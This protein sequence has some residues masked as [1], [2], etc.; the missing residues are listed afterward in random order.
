VRE[1]HITVGIPGAGKSHYA[2]QLVPTVV[3]AVVASD[4]VREEIMGNAHDL[5]RNDDVWQQIHRRVDL[6][7]RN[8]YRILLDATNLAI[9]NRKILLDVAEKTQT[10]TRVAHLFPLDWELCVRRNI[11][12]DLTVPDHAM[13]RMRGF[14]EREC[15]VEQL[16]VE[17][18]D[19]T[20]VL[21]LRD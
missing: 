1:L 19:V 2:A 6:L 8:G 14:Y 7:L 16:T 9:A 3:D 13:K 20:R 15:S 10:T 21:P 4:K 17:G 5:S 18:W 12:R 11:E